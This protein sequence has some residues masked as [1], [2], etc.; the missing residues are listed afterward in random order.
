MK[1]NSIYK[2]LCELYVD[3]YGNCNDHVCLVDL[4]GEEEMIRKCKWVGLDKEYEKEYNEIIE[5]L[6]ERGEKGDSK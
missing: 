5:K 3:S 1:C 6:N 4:L 2:A